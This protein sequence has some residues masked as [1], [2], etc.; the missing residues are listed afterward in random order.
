MAGPGFLETGDRQ[1]S[2]HSCCP[3]VQGLGELGSNRF[4]SSSVG[5]G[6][7]RADGWV[8]QRAARMLTSTGPLLPLAVKMR[9]GGAL[10][11]ILPSGLST[12]PCGLCVEGRRPSDAWEV[13]SGGEWG[14]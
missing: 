9:A 4:K 2:G 6:W 3:S 5:L 1:P 14:H 11:S 13:G 10:G 12:D 8:G 7:A